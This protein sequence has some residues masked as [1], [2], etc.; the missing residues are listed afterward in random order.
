MPQ[1]IQAL[2]ALFIL[3]PGFVS[4]RIARN[5]S[6]PSN[7]T[8]VE[9]IIEALI[10]SFFIYVL[11][12][13]LFGGTLPVDWSTTPDNPLHYSIHVYQGR[14][15]FLSVTPVLWGVLWGALRYHDAILSL[16]R[17]CRITDRTNDVSVWNGTLRALSGSVQVG[18][19]DG[20]EIV[21]WLQRYSDLGEE[22]SLFLEQAAWV[23][24]DGSRIALSGP[25]I[26][27]TDKSEIRYI[28]FLDEISEI[29]T[30]E[31]QP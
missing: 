11:Y 14:L 2:L 13:L 9:R 10:F 1:G 23:G 5:I 19:S 21:G 4:A 20:R 28:M 24:E 15:A 27:L 16:L 22:R 3:L 6:A 29:A 18:L 31:V 17:R 12:L 25:G 30:P 8:D 7:Q 26:L